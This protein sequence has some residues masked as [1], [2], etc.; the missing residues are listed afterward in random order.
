MASAL[1]IEPVP[2]AALSL[3]D[4]QSATIP[5]AILYWGCCRPPLS[6]GKIERTDALLRDIGVKGEIVFRAPILT[7]FL[8][9]AWVLAKLWKAKPGSIIILHDGKG[10]YRNA[11][12][13]GTI[14]ATDRIIPAL[15]WEGYAFV[16]VSD[17]SY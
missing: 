17:I 14:A 3:K 11:T 9:V 10:I 1:L 2:S 16:R 4:T 13:L 15:K 8:P 6:G 12:R 5:I 7:R